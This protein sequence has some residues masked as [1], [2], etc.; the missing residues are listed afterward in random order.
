[1]HIE[2]VQVLRSLMARL[3]QTCAGNNGLGDFHSILISFHARSLHLEDL[4]LTTDG[5]EQRQRSHI[6]CK[7]RSF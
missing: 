4:R 5:G 1:M 3:L 6:P 7:R 2:N